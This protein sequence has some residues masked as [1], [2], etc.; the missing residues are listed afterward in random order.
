MNQR[1]TSVPWNIQICYHSYMPQINLRP[2][3][4][5]DLD[6]FFEHQQ[7]AEAVRMAAFTS[8]DPSDR[9]AFDAHWQKILNDPNVEM[10]AIEV[11]GVVA[12]HIA[13]FVM[14]EK[15]Q[16][17]YWIGRE[18]WGQGVA[19]RA[20]RLLL[21]EIPERPIYA[22]AAFDNTGSLR[23]LEKCGFVRTGSEKFY[24]NARGEEIEEVMFKL[25]H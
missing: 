8:K 22:S 2:V 5:S 23:V 7:D 13:K 4:S 3:T 1:G 17:T 9:T 18:F 16:I 14:Y 20:L 21:D 19:T 25:D 12:G 6:I 11:D 24:A 15:P 10:R